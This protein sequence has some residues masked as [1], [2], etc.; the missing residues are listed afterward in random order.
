MIKAN[1]KPELYSTLAATIITAHTA[2]ANIVFTGIDPDTTL[3]FPGESFGV[4]LNQDQSDGFELRITTY[5]NPYSVNYYSISIQ[6]LGNNYFAKPLTLQKYVDNL[7][8]GQ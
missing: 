5:V 3:N 2:S 6:N 4:D 1:S 8:Y 7:D